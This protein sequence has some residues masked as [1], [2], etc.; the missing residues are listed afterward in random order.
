MGGKRGGLH[1]RRVFLRAE[2]RETRSAPREDGSHQPH[3]VRR[4]IDRGVAVY[5]IGSAIATRLVHTR[6]SAQGAFKN[7]SRRR[8]KADLGAKNSSASS[9]RRLRFLRRVFDPHRSPP[10]LAERPKLF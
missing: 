1:D 8:K 2:R 3:L 6:V 10:L 9:P 4:A 5:C 7:G